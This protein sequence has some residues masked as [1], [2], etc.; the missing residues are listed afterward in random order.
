M[1]SVFINERGKNKTVKGPQN[2]MAIL[3]PTPHRKQEHQEE[4]RRTRETENRARSGW[5]RLPVQ[6]TEG[7]KERL[8]F[9]RK[10][11]WG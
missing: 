8:L 5:G 1:F 4:Q 6:G 11:G 10:G 2:P 3:V 7:H 9:A